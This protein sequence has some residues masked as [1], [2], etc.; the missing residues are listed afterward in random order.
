M[1]IT[2]IGTRGYINART[3][4]HYRHTSTLIMHK[5]TRILI[6]C[7]KDWL[8]KFH[9]LKKYKPQAIFITHAH[10]DHCWGLQ[11]GSPIPVYAT[12]E[13]WQIM[14]DFAITLDKRFLIKP[15]KKIKF[16]SL[17]IRAF[18]IVHSI[19]AP[20]VSYR[21]S[22]GKKTIFYTG[23]IVYIPDRKEA[24]TNID[25]LIADGATINRP[26]IRKSK[27][28]VLFG[29]APIATQLTWCQKEGI[30]RAIITHCGSQI[31]K[32][33]PKEAEKVIENLGNQKGITASIAYDGMSVLV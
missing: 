25:L 18:F 26:M 31:V 6:D 15:R 1:K 10:P 2:F 16:G 24:L 11:D 22:G 7:G 8:G 33:N 14:R 5:N 27:E 29:H 20:A 19:K 30:P 4:L 9:L 28:G 21:I 3:K 12:K 32:A 23:D 13:S 17:V